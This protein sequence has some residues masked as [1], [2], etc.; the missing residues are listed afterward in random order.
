[1][2]S[3]VLLAGSLA[4][5]ARAASVPLAARTSDN[6]TGFSWLE[7]KPTKDL[8][9][10][11]CGGGFLCARLEV[12]LDWSNPSKNATA[13]IGIVKLPATVPDD[14]PTFGGSVLLNPGGPSGSG[15][16]WV[17]VAGPLLQRVLA[18]ERN[19]ELIGFDPRGVNVSTP[20]ADCYKGDE[21]TRTVD[22]VRE[23]GLPAVEDALSY[24]Y[25]HAVGISKICEQDGM[26]GPFAYVNTASVARDMV[27]IVD[28][29]D[30]LR[31]KESG[32]DKPADA[33][34]PRLQYMGHSYGSYLGNVFA[35][36]F[37]ERIGRLMIDAVWDPNDYATGTYHSYFNDAEAIIDLF[38]EVCFEA[39]ENC[40]IWTSGDASAADIKGRVNEALDALAES[41]IPLVSGTTI[42]FLTSTL[43]DVLLVEALYQPQAQFELLAERLGALVSGNHTRLLSLLPG[44]GNVT[45]P[46]SELPPY[47]WRSDV[48]F[49]VV[50]SDVVDGVGSRNMS[51]FEGL[52][53]VFNEQLPTAGGSM[54]RYWGLPCT[55]RTL[56]PP[57][58]F[59]GPFGS[60]APSTDDPKAP[61][62]PLLITSNRLDP[63]TPLRGAVASQKLHAGSSLVIQE[64]A[65]HGFLAG[66]TKCMAEIIREYFNTGKVPENGTVCEGACPPTIPSKNNCTSPLA[67]R[68]GDNFID[69]PVPGL[70]W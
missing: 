21:M 12:P 61:A 8:Q 67:A 10:R 17:Y 34:L 47:T 36:M 45:A 14:D 66:P 24:H 37:P 31:W 39:R 59:T 56:R 33:E 68:D 51:Y 69:L 5:L 40:A 4:A 18:G 58:A 16:N 62:A 70:T 43:A 46:P 54:A 41:P 57:Y 65:G 55:G 29:I 19:Y 26:D 27:E 44:S 9:Y 50:C 13:A 35:S 42:T 11:D 25:Q 20:H 3:S 23:A 22:Q 48:Q 38:Y 64:A 6:T 28:R 53:D 30:E 49:A 52:L 32:R 2:H 15:T 63:I 1:M 60:P 7:T